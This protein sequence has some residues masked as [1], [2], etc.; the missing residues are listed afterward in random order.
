M[1]TG[2]VFHHT[3][4]IIG[5][6]HRKQRKHDHAAYR[7]NHSHNL[8]GQRHRTDGASYGCEVHRRPPQ[9]SPIAGHIRIHTGLPLEEYERAEVGDHDHDADIRHEEARDGIARQITYHNRHGQRTTRKR[10]E[11]D[12]VK[13]VMA[14]M[15]VHLIDDVEIWNREKEEYQ[16]VPE[17][18][19]FIVGEKQLDEKVDDKEHAYPELECHV[20]MVVQEI[21]FL[22]GI[23]RNPYNE[24]HREDQHD[25]IHHASEVSGEFMG[26]PMR[27]GRR[28]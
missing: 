21:D 28:C 10:N 14:Q 12:E 22:E 2:V 24:H 23:N 5:E 25:K 8:S 6:V 11:P 18:P 20:C 17:K 27:G 9:S 1:L 7:Q 15:D 26:S 3:G 4:N 16:P 19:P 13:R